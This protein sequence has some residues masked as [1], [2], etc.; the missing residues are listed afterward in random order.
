MDKKYYKLL[1]LNDFSIA[2]VTPIANT[3][4]SNVSLLISDWFLNIPPA[5]IIPLSFISIDLFNK[6]ILFVIMESINI[7][8]S[9]LISLHMLFIIFVVI[10]PVFSNTDGMIEDTIV[11]FFFIPIFSKYEFTFIWFIVLGPT[12]SAVCSLFPMPTIKI[13]LPYFI[14]SLSKT[15]LMI[16]LIVF[17]F[18]VHFEYYQI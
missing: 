3:L 5:D 16:V 10:I 6:S 13:W 14:F 1:L 12:E 2:V 18:S 11:P 15:Y 8:K 17:L 7:T 9:G 4:I